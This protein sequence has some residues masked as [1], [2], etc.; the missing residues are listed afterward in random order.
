MNEIIIKEG[1]QE[2]RFRIDKYKFIICNDMDNAF[3]YKRL[4]LKFIRQVND[5][6][7]YRETNYIERSLLID[8]KE[9]NKKTDIFTIVQPDLNLSEELK[10]SSKSIIWKYFEQ[11]F[12]NTVYQDT[13]QTLQILFDS[14]EQEINSCSKIKIKFQDITI[15]N[16]L[17]LSSAYIEK[18]HMI[19]N[20]YDLNYEETIHIQLEM[21]KIIEKDPLLENI[22]VFMDVPNISNEII[23]DLNSFNKCKFIILSTNFSSN[24]NI[25][26]FYFIGNT[27][28]DFAND[29][30][31][32]LELC[33]KSTN[34]YNLLEVKNMLKNY[35]YDKEQC[36]DDILRLLR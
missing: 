19:C 29:E 16:L 20:E 28:I 8:N 13:I 24:I 34:A 32:F 31:I 27:N 5:S 4:C 23:N 36:A 17:K 21:L 18:D 1:N 35:I 11:Q 6:E 33:E 10:M 7:Y 3:M 2:Y 14:L 25:E 15:K 12:E 22:L 9:F 30:Q 26:N